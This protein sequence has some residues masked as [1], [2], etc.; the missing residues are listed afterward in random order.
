MFLN[1]QWEYKVN[2]EKIGDIELATD[3][4]D[5]ECEHLYIHPK[6]IDKCKIC[7]AESTSQPDSR[8][9]EVLTQGCL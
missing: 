9:Q 1:N 5:C 6:T 4:W 8:F 2:I 3:Y 7:V